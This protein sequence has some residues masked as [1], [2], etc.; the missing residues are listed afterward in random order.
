MPLTTPP[1]SP[2]VRSCS[3]CRR[4]EGAGLFAAAFV[5]VVPSY[6]SRSVAGSYDCEGVA[7]F[8]LVNVCHMFVRTLN[9]GTRDEMVAGG[10]QPERLSGLLC[11]DTAVCIHAACV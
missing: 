1:P 4:N 7:I 10:C 9:T 8:A 2:T 11:A 5:A 3:S 6:I